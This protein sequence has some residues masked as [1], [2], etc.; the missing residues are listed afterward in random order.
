MPFSN[1]W[2]TTQPPDTQLANLLGQ[3]IRSLK[4]DIQQRMGAQ[5]GT[6][7]ARWNPALD[8]QPANWT[9]VLY[10]TT[11]TSQ[12]FQWSGAAW[13]DVTTLVIGVRPLVILKDSSLHVHTGDVTE[14]TIYT[15]VVTAGQL[16]TNGVIRGYISF[17]ETARGVTAPTIRVRFGGQLIAVQVPT[18]APPNTNIL[19]FEMGN[20][21]VT[22]SQ[23]NIGVFFQNTGSVPV[24][25][26]ST[27][28]TTLV[29]NLTVTMQNVQPGDSQN[30]N[31]FVCE[32]L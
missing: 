12:V 11:D 24:G 16:G 3:D 28:D 25:Q 31:Q 9:G 17:G 22:N 8:T 4:L 18:V 26:N 15:A 29:Q 14:D 2:D 30:F 5:S 10:F 21:G 13:V 19:T 23:F 32:I 1:F 6:L 7:A 20:R 27:V